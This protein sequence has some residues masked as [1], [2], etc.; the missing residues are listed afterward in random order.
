MG[1]CQTSITWPA[2]V[3]FVKMMNSRGGC[4]F[5]LSASNEPARSFSC[6]FLPYGISITSPMDQD[7]WF[8]IF[9]YHRKPLMTAALKFRRGPGP[10]PASGR[11]ATNQRPPKGHKEQQNSHNLS[12]EPTPR[13]R[14]R[15][16]FVCHFQ[17][18]WW[19][20]TAQVTFIKK[21]HR[22]NSRF[23]SLF[24]AQLED[25]LFNEFSSL[26]PCWPAPWP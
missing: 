15:L 17:T 8:C 10:S 26:L 13:P 23:I 3:Y 2:A 7:K 4:P 24:A 6:Y 1:A 20:T 21:Y 5:L 12:N 9:H 16:F 11:R 19:L 22:N 14:G 18:G 25:N